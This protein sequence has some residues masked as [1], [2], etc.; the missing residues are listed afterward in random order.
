M[1]DGHGLLTVLLGPRACPP[2]QV[3]HLVGLLV[4]QA[5]TQHVREQM[6]V[7]IPPAAIVERDQ[8]QVPAV[9]GLQHDLAPALA[10]DGIT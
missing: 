4:Q 5:R 6:V 3:R 1:L 10:G 9:Q 2:V 7:A 8:E